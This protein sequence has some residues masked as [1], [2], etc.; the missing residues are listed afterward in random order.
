VTSEPIAALLATGPR[1]ANVGV[2]D[3]AETLVRQEAA[4]VQ[5]EWAPPPELDEDLADLLDVLG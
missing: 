3:F 1:V 4:V 2:R 5:V